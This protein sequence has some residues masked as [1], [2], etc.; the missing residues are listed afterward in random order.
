M[1]YKISGI[2]LRCQF[3]YKKQVFTM[4]DFLI[5]IYLLRGP[6]LIVARIDIWCHRTWSILVQVLACCLMSPSHYPNQCWLIMI[7]EV[8]W[9]SPRGNCTENA[10]NIYSYMS[11]KIT[12]LKSQPHLSE[13]NEL[14]WPISKFKWQMSEITCGPLGSVSKDHFVYAPSQ[15]ETTLQCNV[16]SH[17]LDTFIK[18]SL[19]SWQQP[20]KDSWIAG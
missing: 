4:F 7:T 14:N 11:V 16:V 5:L 13:A 6:Q 15:W 12:N 3:F 1:L 19:V 17:W 10:Q 2:L 18:W 8:L 20:S 9:H